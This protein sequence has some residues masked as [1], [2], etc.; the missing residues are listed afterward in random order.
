[1]CYYCISVVLVN[2]LLLYKCCISLCVIADV[3]VGAGSSCARVG[4]GQPQ[5]PSCH[6]DGRV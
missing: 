5:H 4:L 2:I 6:R 1:M 3:S